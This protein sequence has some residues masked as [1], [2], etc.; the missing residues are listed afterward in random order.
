MQTLAPSGRAGRHGARMA[1]A[2]RAS[3]TGRGRS[4]RLRRRGVR[5]PRRSPAEVAGGIAGFLAVAGATAFVL[6]ELHPSLLLSRSMD[7][8]GDN[9]AHVA[10]VHYFVYHLLP[11]GQLS[12]WDPQWFDG[13]P[14]Y[15]FY[16]P[17]PALLV[18][19]LTAVA[20]YAVAFKLVTVSGLVA[21]PLA[22]WAFGRLAGFARPVPALMGVAM[23]PFLFNTSYEIDGGNI[24]STLAGEFSFTLALVF[25]LLF[26]GTLA[27]SLETGRGLWLPAVL[28]GATTLC[29]VVPAMFFAVVA[30]FLVAGPGP[31]RRFLR[32]AAAGAVGTLLAAFYLVPFASGLPYTSSM[33]YSRVEG[34]TSNLFPVDYR[35]VLLLAAA[36]VVL[37]LWRH[38]R[39][40]LVLAAAATAA[41]AAFQLLPSGQ[42][43]NGRWLPFWFLFVA[44]LAAW[45][46]GEAFRSAAGWLELGSWHAGT[47]TVIGTLGALALVAAGLGD[48]PG[49]HTPAA[50][51]SFVPS[52]I[53]WNYTGYQGKPG[54]P[55]YRRIVA[56]LDRVTAAHGCGRLQYEYTPEIQDAF[57][58][59]MALMSL[60]LW[61]HG[62][63]QTTSGLYFESSTTTPFHFLDQSE[64]SLQPSEPVS[65]LDYP[66]FDVADGVRHL[67][68]MGVR[69]FLASS[70]TAEAQ[71]AAD[72]ALVRVGSTPGEPDVVD[73]AP[74]GG[75]AGTVWAVYLVRDAPLVSPLTRLP[76]REPSSA[77][78]WLATG[79]RWYE[80]P[81]DW[82]AELTRSGPASWPAA[83]PGTLVQPSTRAA[84]PAVTISD[85]RVGDESLSFEVSRT[86]VPVLVKIPYFPNWHASGARGPY[87][88]MPNLMVVVPTARRVSLAY[89]A[90]RAD[91]VG[92]VATLV[93]AVALAGLVASSPPRPAPGDP[94]PSPAAEVP[95]LGAE[96]DGPD[97]R[98]RASG[99]EEP[100]SEFAAGTTA[101]DG[102]PD[103]D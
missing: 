78:Q 27:R 91:V 66:A 47:A 41:A 79:L 73:G 8:G 49:Y 84:L 87:E 20:P 25:G 89:G 32:V 55:L 26:L 39:R 58:S 68:L 77:R 38:D 98:P 56:M 7:V 18:G 71:A 30:L 88:A 94:P 9:A 12:G 1:A 54:W 15:V 52:W 69:Y 40:A 6:A 97:G 57:G 35:L 82:S 3:A 93:G 17:L 48:L 24:A 72:P 65:G 102:Q 21:M 31:R 70:P 81:A 33:G 5:P 50:S 14:A 62:C 34:F 36:G 19:L 43:Y 53:S 75:P 60:P 44:L 59:T 99:A 11:R 95:L 86:G 13:F 101:P 83:R 74:N 10:A 45:T 67:Q 16:F 64:F 63:I 61:T 80:D 37:A 22:A 23:L 51:R 90:S 85:V 46:L 103:G 2:T 28:Y 42:V 4:D 92:D 76:T 29:H 96:A 100:A